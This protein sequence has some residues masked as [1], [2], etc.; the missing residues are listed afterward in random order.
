MCLAVEKMAIERSKFK[1]GLYRTVKAWQ[2][3]FTPRLKAKDVDYVSAAQP[4]IFDRL[5][6]GE[7]T[8][9]SPGENPSCG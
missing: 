5:C 1:H 8:L 9:F 7:R 3:S 2:S 6:H 4:S